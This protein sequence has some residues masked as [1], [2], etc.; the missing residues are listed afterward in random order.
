[1]RNATRAIALLGGLALSG[2]VLT[3]T[4][5][6]ADI[7]PVEEAGGINWYLSVFGGPKWG[8]GDIHVRDIERERCPP[9][10]TV[11]VLA[12]VIYDHEDEL[13]GEVDDGFLIGGAIGAQISENFRGEIEVSHASLDTKTEVTD[14]VLFDSGA[15]YTEKDNDELS[16]LFIMANVWFGFPLSSVFSPYIGGGVGVAHVDA[17]FG[18]GAFPTGQ[19]Q[20]DTFSAS[21][22]ADSWNFAYQLGAG[23]LIG[24][25]DHFAIDLGYRFKA[26]PNVELDDPVFC[27]GKECYPPVVDFK[28]DDDFDIHEHV[29]QIGL[30]IGF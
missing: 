21:I 17:D 5:K 3:P 10:I 26:I 7:A 30:T 24:L 23:I 9:A 19:P 11:C 6:A 25:S 18:V 16:E 13:H 1:M 28:A 14:Y 2:L 15:Y 4:V 12:P 20:S 8:D 22:D 29:A 27:G